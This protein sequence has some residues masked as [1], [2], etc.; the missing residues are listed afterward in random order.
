MIFEYYI[1]VGENALGTYVDVPEEHLNNAN[2]MKSIFS[3][4]HGITY[5]LILAFNP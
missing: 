4:L 5:T 3:F 2:D 1:T